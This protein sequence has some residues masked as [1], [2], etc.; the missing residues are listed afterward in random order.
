MVRWSDLSEEE[1]AAVNAIAN[2]LRVFAVQKKFGY[3]DRFANSYS[4]ES[5]KH[6]LYEL[7]RDLKSLEARATVEEG[8]KYVTVDNIKI[9]LYVPSKSHV[10]TFVKLVEKDLAIAK[11]VAT[12]SL[13]Y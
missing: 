7:L 13:T 2:A 9:A 8:R 11:L 1:R 5:V 12:L 3:V 6:V 4:A 10:E